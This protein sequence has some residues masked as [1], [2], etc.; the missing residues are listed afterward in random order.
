MGIFLD[1][2]TLVW[3][4][5]G[6]PRLGRDARAII[7]GDAPLFVSAVTA[8][9]YGDLQHRRRLPIVAAFDEVLEMLDARIIDLPGKLWTMATSL[10]AI[11]GDPVDRMLVAHT[12]LT[13]FLLVTVDSNIRKYP[14]QTAW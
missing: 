1:T 9:E 5:E 4:A 14:I 7:E 2:H 8:W 13:N 3:V 6:S 10:P 12:M 11:H